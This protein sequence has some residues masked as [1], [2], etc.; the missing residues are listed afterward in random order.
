VSIERRSSGLE[1]E[2]ILQPR[3]NFE[4]LPSLIIGLGDTDILPVTQERVFVRLTADQDSSP[5]V[6]DDGA[7]SAGNMFVR[8]GK[9]RSDN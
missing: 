3:N 8:G 4:A 7:P 6:L 5:F 1:N 9:V 2:Q